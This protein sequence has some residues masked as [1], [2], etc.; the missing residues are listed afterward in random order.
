M[1]LARLAAVDH[2]RK[3]IGVRESPPNSNRGP[4][5]D[6]WQKRV[7]GITGY[8]WCAAFIWCMFDDIGRKITVPKRDID[9]NEGPRFPLNPG[10][11]R[12]PNSTHM[13]SLLDNLEGK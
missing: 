11:G 7:N 8:P 12:T 13:Q 4:V 6:R 3:Y 2:A 1:R 5:I 9:T 10:V